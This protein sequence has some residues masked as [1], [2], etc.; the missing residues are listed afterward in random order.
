[1]GKTVGYETRRTTAIIIPST[2]PAVLALITGRIKN[3]RQPWVFPVAMRSHTCCY[4][5]RY[6]T[7]GG[8][9]TRVLPIAY[10]I[11]Q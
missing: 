3:R 11:V 4:T 8:G 9:P 5:S 10:I 2:R 6:N 1:M 7:V